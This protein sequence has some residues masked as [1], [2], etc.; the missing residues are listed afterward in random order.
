MDKPNIAH[1]LTLLL[2]SGKANTPE[3]IVAAYCE[4]LPK[5]KEAVS[6]YKQSHMPKGKVIP[7]SGLFPVNPQSEFTGNSPD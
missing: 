7:R 1:D 6:E 5:V 2:I 3:S 4:T